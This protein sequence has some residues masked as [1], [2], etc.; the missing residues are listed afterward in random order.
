MM[1][2]ARHLM[3]DRRGAAAAEMGLVVPLIFVLLFGSAEIGNFMWQQHV[4][5]KAVRDGA[6]FAGRKP[7]ADYSC[8]SV[9]NSTT[10][11]EIQNVTATGQV[12]SGAL[13]RLPGFTWSQV[14]LAV[15]CSSSTNTGIYLNQTNG[16]PVIRV[17]ATVPYTPL[18]GSLIFKPLTLSL[19]AT[20]QSAVMGL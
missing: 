5:T 12:A 7:F 10:A 13:T 6:R 18:L 16:A 14:S 15:T 1:R 20:S 4:V 2:R 17:R 8:S 11:R 19:N 3:R 9:T